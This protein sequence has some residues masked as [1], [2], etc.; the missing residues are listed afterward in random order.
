MTD[1]VGNVAD[2]MENAADLMEN[3]AIEKPLSYALSIGYLQE[4]SSL[5]CRI[6]R[7]PREKTVVS[8]RETDGFRRGNRWIPAWTGWKPAWSYGI[9]HGLE[10]TLHCQK[11]P[12]SGRYKYRRMLREKH[13]KA[14]RRRTLSELSRPETHRLFQFHCFPA[15][16]DLRS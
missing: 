13:E 3:V 12:P 8:T 9:N 7:F 6:H 4:T 11:S 15:F 1:K 2:L 16:A 5:L 14:M 10:A